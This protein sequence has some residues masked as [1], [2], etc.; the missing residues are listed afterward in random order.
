MA[1]SFTGW[2]YSCAFTALTSHDFFPAVEQLVM[3]TPMSIWEGI[4]QCRRVAC[5]HNLRSCS[6]FVDSNDRLPGG[7]R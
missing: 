2:A 4:V 3:A 6:R 5:T 7:N 1:G